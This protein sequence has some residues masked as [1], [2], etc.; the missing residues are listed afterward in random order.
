MPSKPHTF[1]EIRA[2]LVSFD[3]VPRSDEGVVQMVRRD[4]ARMK[5]VTKQK[6]AVSG[7]NA[8]RVWRSEKVI[9]IEFIDLS[10]TEERGIR[11]RMTYELIPSFP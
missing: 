7:C 6:R 11:F 8:Y 2:T 3:L 5:G 10:K 9:R 4:L 1:P